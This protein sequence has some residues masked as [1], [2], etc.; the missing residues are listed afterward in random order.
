MMWI[1]R[2]FAERYVH[3]AWNYISQLQVF[4][5]LAL[6]ANRLNYYCM[7]LKMY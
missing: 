7:L 1:E 5:H 6:S 3:T 4:L 2:Q